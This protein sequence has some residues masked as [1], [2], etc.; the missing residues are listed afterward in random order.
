M[1]RKR[2]TNSLESTNRGILYVKIKRKANI[3]NLLP[4]KHS[5][6]KKSGDGKK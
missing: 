3:G 2:D 6:S 1:E 4:V 5:E